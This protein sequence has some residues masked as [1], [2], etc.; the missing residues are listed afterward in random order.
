MPIIGLAEPFDGP[1][2]LRFSVYSISQKGSGIIHSPGGAQ[3]C[4]QAEESIGILI[5]VPLLA[6]Q[7]PHAVR[8]LSRRVIIICIKDVLVQVKRL[9]PVQFRPQSGFT[10][11]GQIVQSPGISCFG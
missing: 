9:F 4:R 5:L 2:H 1:S 11:R 3:P 8:R 10:G 7:K 6:K